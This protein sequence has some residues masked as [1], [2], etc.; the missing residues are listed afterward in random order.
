MAKNIDFMGATFP[1]V[2]SIRL[3]QHEG[4]LVSFDD[5]SD[6]DIQPAD[7]TQ[8]KIGYAQGQRVVGTATPST[9]TIQ[10][11]SVTENGTYTAPSGVDGYSPVTVSVSGGGGAS[12]V[13]S[14]EFNKTEVGS[15]DI[16]L[17]YTGNGYP[18][19]VVV[20]PTGG[21]AAADITALN[22]SSAITLLLV[23]KSYAGQAPSYDGTTTGGINSATMLYRC[24]GSSATKYSQGAVSNT[25]YSQ[26][27]AT[28]GSG[29]YLTI[30]SATRI[31][32][33]IS[34]A[35]AFGFAPNIDYTYHIIYT[36]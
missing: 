6:G 35:S 34:A 5:T 4:G 27:S 23:V 9:P 33:C 10:S 14:G 19:A 30:K 3:P 16:D 1:D 17:P 2:P 8:G 25:P 13:V 22:R 21:S 12:N 36:T 15:Y 7:V 26:S 24:K 29:T 20:Y 28:Q 18:V 11:L 32:I 31:S